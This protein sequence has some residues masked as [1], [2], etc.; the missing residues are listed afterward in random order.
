MNQFCG[1]V[2]FIENFQ[3]EKV[4]NELFQDKI[5][6]IKDILDESLFEKFCETLANVVVVSNRSKK[7][8]KDKNCL[9]IKLDKKSLLEIFHTF[10]EKDVDG[11]I[12]VN[13]DDKSK[14]KLIS[15][16]FSKSYLF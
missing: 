12:S 2:L 14:L 11:V 13:E 15:G 3:N 5:V 9:C 7:L 6:F 1:K 4:K 8:N 16:S 10:S